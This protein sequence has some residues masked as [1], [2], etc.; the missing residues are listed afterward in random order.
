MLAFVL[1]LVLFWSYHLN[2]SV[3]PLGHIFA[4]GLVGSP[5]SCPN[6]PPYFRQETSFLRMR[7]GVR[8]L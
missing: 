5:P 4:N 6:S 1:A 7:H 8:T 2:V 3:R